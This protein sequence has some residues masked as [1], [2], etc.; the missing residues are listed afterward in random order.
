MIPPLCMCG[1]HCG[2]EHYEL[3]KLIGAMRKKKDLSG[4]FEKGPYFE[5]LMIKI[6]H[7]ELVAE[8]WR[9]RKSH[10]SPISWGEWRRAV[11]YLPVSY[12]MA[13]VDVDR[14][15]REISNRCSECRERIRWYEAVHQM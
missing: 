9:R 7:D 5:P 4:Y 15:I 8:A 1:S 10:W 6:R 13:R 11:S 3:H 12:L 14:S 2:G